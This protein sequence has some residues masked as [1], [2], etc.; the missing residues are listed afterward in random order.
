MPCRLPAFFSRKGKGF[1][2]QFSS[3]FKPSAK[4][5]AILLLLACAGGPADLNE[6]TSYFLP[7][8]TD[9]QP[10]D[11]RYHYTQQFLYLDEYSDS[12]RLAENTNAEAWAKYAGVS[13]DIAYNYFYSESANNTLPNRLML[14]GNKA[15][16]AYLQFAKTVDKAYQPAT[17]AWEEGRKDSLVLVESYEKAKQ[18]ARVATDGFLKERYGFQA[19][20]LAMML[21][22][23][24]ACVQLYDEL[25][26]PLKTKSFI[27]DWAYARRAG[28]S[29]AMGDTAKAIYEFAQVFERCP[30]RR[31]EADLSL[32]MKGVMFQEK[33]LTYCQNDAEKAAVYALCAIQP[34][35]DALPFLK[36]I[37]ELNPKNS[38]IELIAAREI[39]KTE[40]YSLGEIPYTED[41]LAFE[42]H[43]K[44]SPSYFEQLQAFTAEIAAN[45]TLNNSAF[46]YTAA[47]YLAYVN[48]DYDKA[49]DF[50][51]KAQAQ[52]T[53]NNY[54]K[55][56]IALQQ[57]LL[58]I[59]KQES[60]T[61]EFETQAIGMLET[62][63]GSDNF[64]LVNAYTRACGLLAKMYR[65]Q[66]LDD[67]KSGGFLSSCGKKSE[68]VPA[69]H[70]AKAFLLEAAASWQSR[71]QNADYSPIFATNKDR[72]AIENSASTAT[73]EQV[74]KY[75][76]VPTP[77]DFD[78][79]LMKLSGVDADYLY[80][81]LGRKYLIQHQYAKAAE[82]FGKVTPIHWTAETSVF[83]TYFD[84]N[85]FHLTPDNGESK[86][87]TFTPATFAKRMTELESQM[88]KGDAK[89]AYLL[90]CG[91]Y[92]I[93]YWGNSWI[94]S[95]RQR[96]SSEYQYMYPP[97]DLS[98]EDYYVMTKAHTYFD[99]AMQ[100]K[101]AE[102]AAKAAFGAALCEQ[103]AFFIYQANE[104]RD[105]G[106]GEDEQTAFQKRMSSEE[107]KRL[108]KYF[109]LLRSK[110]A[111]TQYTKEVLEEC[112]LYRDFVGGE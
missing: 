7:E 86:K 4:T 110:Y 84:E 78:K 44:E 97:R 3:Y 92:N 53:Q 82:A 76:Q 31:R 60:I 102:L 14:K 17:Y 90:G 27:S 106:Y 58:L 2:T 57:M 9:T 51:A 112:S 69:T 30:S 62:F 35:Q 13:N 54:L 101:D 94:L 40:Y 48:K 49:S 66:P 50:L 67:K 23:P 83:P 29:M 41:T 89:A 47:S 20:K 68:E 77:T 59:A 42:A 22:Q 10:G 18:S 24:E 72:Y 87:H 5:I 109:A 56:Q 55:Q 96:S 111:T 81:V 8:S 93:G 105:L 11:G 26:K 52:P 91:A 45:K 65:G 64:R 73:I 38:L 34:F 63:G 39:N 100:T 32:R 46:W 25:I 98:G 95:Q 104:G 28:A 15:A 85:P 6:F 36:K 37:V 75:F 80:V 21:D 79:R 33:A 1:K 12:L 74:I 70:L 107:K 103:S 99:K 108:G 71:P 43:R 16:I 88:N 61:P 19:V